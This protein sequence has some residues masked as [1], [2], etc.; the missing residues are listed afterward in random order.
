MLFYVSYSFFY[1]H[2]SQ[3]LQDLGLPTTSESKSEPSSE[4]EG[5][6]DSVKAVAPTSST[7]EDV[8]R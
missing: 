7:S 2:F 4:N 3:V 8:C 6:Q 1:F 5:S